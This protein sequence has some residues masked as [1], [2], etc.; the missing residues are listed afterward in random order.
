M[1]TK[2]QTAVQTLLSGGVIAHPT[3]TCY[4]LAV[5][6]FNKEAVSKLYSLKKMALDKPVSILVRDLEEAE[7]YG[8]FNETARDLAK[9]YWPGPLTII[10]PRTKVLPSWINF[11]MDSVGIRI[12]SNKKARELVEAFG[13]PL[14][15]TSANIHGE[16]QAYTVQ[17][18]LDQGLV[19]DFILDSGKIGPVLPST[20]VKVVGDEVELI[21]EGPIQWPS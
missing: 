2:I 17:E 1:V 7:H 14:T 9:K 19:P 6:I 4:G 16:L 15:T 8:V 21:R 11:G 18:L 12:S 10:L 3:E 20:I 13:G 5:D